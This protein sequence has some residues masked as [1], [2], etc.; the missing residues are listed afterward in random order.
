MDLA[1]DYQP[2]CT[3]CGKEIYK[4]TYRQGGRW[5]PDYDPDDDPVTWRHMNGYAVCS[6]PGFATPRET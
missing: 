4:G 3:H 2:L 1:T 6:S 5:E